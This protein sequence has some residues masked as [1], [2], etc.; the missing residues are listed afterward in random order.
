MRKATDKI[1]KRL[2]EK[3]CLFNLKWP[4]IE[5]AEQKLEKR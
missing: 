1:L 2:E 4:Q 3:K 5:K